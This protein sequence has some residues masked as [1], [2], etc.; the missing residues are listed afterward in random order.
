MEYQGEH[1]VAHLE[2]RISELGEQLEMMGDTGDLKELLFII[3][4]PGW[5]TPAEY[6]LVNG[7]IDAMQQQVGMLAAMRQTL[8]N[9]SRA[10]ARQADELNPQP[11]PPGEVS[12]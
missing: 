11:L 8:L 3:K 4:R 10:I 1:H 6:L 2:R 9:G 7:V 12:A 5:T